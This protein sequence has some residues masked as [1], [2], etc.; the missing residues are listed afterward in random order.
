MI[1]YF[2]ESYI[3]S[4]HIPF[5][6]S[7][8]YRSVYE[9]H[10]L[11][12]KTPLLGHPLSCAEAWRC[13]LAASSS[14]AGPTFPSTRTFSTGPGGIRT[15][16]WACRLYIY[17][18]IYIYVCVY[19]HIHMLCI[20][21]MLYYIYIILGVPRRAGGLRRTARRR[22]AGRDYSNTFGLFNSNI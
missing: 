5:I 19:T 20:Y 10:R 11:F 22:R 6:S 9:N 17:I 13:A 12:R 15:S 4:I 16:R 8:K 3:I 2:L 14:S 18:Y 7:H 21:V 1:H